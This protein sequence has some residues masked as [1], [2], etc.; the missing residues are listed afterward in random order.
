MSQGELHALALALFLPRATMSASP[1]RFVVLDD[2]IQAMDP[3]KFDGFVAV[4]AELA[5]DRQVIVLSHDDRL[6]Q[7]I[8]YLRAPARILDVHRAANSKVEVTSAGDPADRYIADALAL[9]HDEQ[10]PED[11]WRRVLPVL[12]RMALEAAAQDVFMAGRF[13]AGADRTDVEGEWNAARRTRQRVGLA[14][15]DGPDSLDRWAARV[16]WRGQA[17]W[18]CGSANHERLDG[19]PIAAIEDVKKTVEDIRKGQR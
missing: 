8:R 14:V 16:R 6:P 13:T 2:P 5:R 15:P 18:I 4:L 9:A 17:L 10:V 3:A 1:F 7:A 12:C 19:D 11:V